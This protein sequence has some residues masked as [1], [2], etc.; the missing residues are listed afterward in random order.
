M[1]VKI[2]YV[3]VATVV[4]PLCGLRRCFDK[5]I[6]QEIEDVSEKNF[7]GSKMWCHLVLSNSDNAETSLVCKSPM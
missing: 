4:V 3:T 1:N 5:E 7:S 2:S 6:L